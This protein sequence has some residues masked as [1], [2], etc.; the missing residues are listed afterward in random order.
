MNI[1]LARHA[2]TDSP[3]NTYAGST[4][5]PLSVAGQKQ[6]IELAGLVKE[7]QPSRIFCSPMLRARQTLDAITCSASCK[8]D[9]FDG[10]R[11]V[12]FG[13]WEGLHFDE[14]SS[15]YPDLT[16]LWMKQGVDFQ[17]PDGESGIHFCK[18]IEKSA[19]YIASLSDSEVLV[20]AHG[21]VIRAMICF[22]LGIGF[23][24]YL[25]F[26]I[27]PARLSMVEVF[28]GDKGILSLLNR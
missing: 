7:Y 18:R 25:L 12:D 13:R 21:G 4:D 23:D 15:Q 26:N 5:L 17:F 1:L 22:Y 2:Q 28:E 8:I 20:I 14:I 11:E 10:L 19:R 16:N 6:A 3:L 27:K 9:I 24:N